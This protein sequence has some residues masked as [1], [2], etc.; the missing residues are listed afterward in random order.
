MF[1]ILHSELCLVSLS[2]EKVTIKSNW[3]Y[4]KY[5]IIRNALNYKI[6]Y[7]NIYQAVDLESLLRKHKQVLF[8]HLSFC[9]LFFV[10]SLG[11]WILVVVV[12][13]IAINQRQQN[14]VNWLV[15]VFEETNNL[16]VILLIK[17]HYSKVLTLW[18]GK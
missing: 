1:S 6:E 8:L 13:A 14:S 4:S 18:H 12:A 10:F 17:K 2:P 3:N 16:I 5:W 15:F 11:F 9:L 7:V